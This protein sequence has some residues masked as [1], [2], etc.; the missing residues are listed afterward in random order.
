MRTIIAL[1]LLCSCGIESRA[2]MAAGAALGDPVDCVI[3]DPD[4]PRGDPCSCEA[5]QPSCAELGCPLRPSGDGDI[6][7]P[8]EPCYSSVTCYCHVDTA[9]VACT[10]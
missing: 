4:V 8:W 3:C 10:P 7:A 9:M 5:P 6:N 1:L 2:P